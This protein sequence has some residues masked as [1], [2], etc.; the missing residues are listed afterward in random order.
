[1]RFPGSASW[2]VDVKSGYLCVLA[3]YVRQSAGLMTAGTGL[4]GVPLLTGMVPALADALNASVRREASDQWPSW[5]V[6]IVDREFRDR[7]HRVGSAPARV[8][9]HHQIAE[10]EAIYDPPMFVSLRERPALQSAVRKAFPGFTLWESSQQ[11]AG[12]DTAE[13]SP[14]DWVVMKQTA[15]DVAFDRRVSIDEVQASIA[16]LPV[17]GVWWHC[18]APGAVL[19]SVA[20]A[21]DPIGARALLRDAFDSWVMRPG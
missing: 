8:P 9:G 13:E 15:E 12:R 18:A 6:E 16:I 4:A 7:Q 1:M 3:L 20:A 10:Q 11:P 14:L 21:A 2:R 17:S 5:W 19:C